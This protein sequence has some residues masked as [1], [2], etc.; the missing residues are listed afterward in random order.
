LLV[1]VCTSPASHAQSQR[2]LQRQAAAQVLASRAALNEQTLLVVA[3]RHANVWMAHEIASMLGE[4][5]D[6]RLVPVMGGGG[7]DNLKDLLFLRGV[8]LAFVSTNV[9][10]HPKIGETVGGNLQQRLV[11]ITRLYGEE[12][13]L[14]A[15]RAVSSVQDLK[16]RK[17]AVPAAEGDVAFTAT[18]ILQRL[19]IQADVVQMDA[20]TAM[21]QVRSGEVAAVLL[22]G[23]KPLPMVSGLPKDGSFRLLDVGSGPALGEGYA[24]AAFRA[25][26]YP[27]LIP[28]GAAIETVSIGSVLLANAMKENEESY[29]RIARFVPHFFKG[30]SELTGAQRHPKW[31]EVNLGAVLTG[32]TRFAPA[33]AWLHTATHA[34]AERLQV[35][36]EEFLRAANVPGA[37]S[38]SPAQ[39]QKLFDEF[40]AW[41]RNS[42]ADPAKVARP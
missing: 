9:L 11:Y 28:P 2:T 13:H 23:G 19:G 42:V 10:A 32:W 36:F 41:T 15:G 14:L 30:V 17:V 22:I 4:A 18:D 24:P 27:S 6:V 37:A 31:A 20:V 39:R 40:V 38:L 5:P 16:G 12:V 7:L 26:D 35:S 21:D 34:Q 33:Q 25:S 29:R 8:D 1:V 3:A